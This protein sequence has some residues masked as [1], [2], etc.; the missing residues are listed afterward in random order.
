MNF[1]VHLRSSTG[2]GGNSGLICRNSRYDFS[3]AERLDQKCYL[4]NYTR[5]TINRMHQHRTTNI[6]F[7]KKPSASNNTS[8]TAGGGGR[9]VK[10]RK[11]IGV[12]PYCRKFDF[13]I[14]FDATA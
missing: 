14:S 7:E 13:Q 8:S 1:E 12:S 9:S 5:N 2:E 4:K 3:N 10:N 11:P 6:L